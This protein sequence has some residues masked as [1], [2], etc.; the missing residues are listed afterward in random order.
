[1]PLRF[2]MPW[3]RLCHGFCIHTLSSISNREAVSGR[4]GSPF[5][6]EVLGNEAGLS[7]GCRGTYGMTASSCR[8]RLGGRELR[9]ITT[10]VL[11][12]SGWGWQKGVGGFCTMGRSSRKVSPS[13]EAPRPGCGWVW[14]ADGRRDEKRRRKS[15]ANSTIERFGPTGKRGEARWLSKALVHG[16]LGVPNGG[17]GPFATKVVLGRSPPGHAWWTR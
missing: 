6:D 7:T 3:F 2:C 16:R 14:T 11:S 12:S 10:W 9:A 5:D 15:H 13:A 8:G 17:G 4:G 1:M